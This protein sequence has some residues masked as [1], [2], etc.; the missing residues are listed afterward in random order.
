MT[1]KGDYNVFAACKML[2]I[3]YSTACDIIKYWQSTGRLYRSAMDQRR[4]EAI[5]R[6]ANAASSG[7]GGRRKLIV[8]I[9]VPDLELSIPN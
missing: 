9:E 5:D 3:K 8:T 4:S 7:K 2:H 6:R 1:Q